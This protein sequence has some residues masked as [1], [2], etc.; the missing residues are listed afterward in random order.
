MLEAAYLDEVSM[1]ALVDCAAEDNV[2]KFGHA[3]RLLGEQTEGAATTLYTDTTE[4]DLTKVAFGRH[5][6]LEVVKLIA[7]ATKG[8]SGWCAVVQVKCILGFSCRILDGD[9][10]APAVGIPNVTGG[11]WSSKIVVG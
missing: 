7:V 3:M 2:G 11:A 6:G 9:G 4:G 5:R 10:A 8:V 1:E